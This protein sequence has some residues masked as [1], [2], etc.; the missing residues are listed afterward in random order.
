[1]R[2][3]I[4]ILIF[5]IAGAATL[6]GEETNS[7]ENKSANERTFFIF[8]EVT[9]SSDTGIGG[10]M[11]I[12]KAYHTEQPRISTL[13]GEVRYTE[14]KQF[15]SYFGLDHYFKKNR[16]RILFT[17]K[18]ARFP[19]LFYGIGNETS[20]TRPEDYSPEYV[21]ALMF[22]ERSIPS[23]IRIQC[24]FYLHNQ[25]LISA[26]PGG[27]LQSPGIAWSGGRFDAGP[28][29]A[30]LRDTRDNI[31]AARSGSLVK[32]EYRDMMFQNRGNS[33]SS[34]RGDIRAFFSPF[35]DVV[36]GSMG[37]FETIHG[38]A[39]FYLLSGLGGDELLRGYEFERFRDR[40]MLL[41]QQDLRFPVAGP[42]GG[43][44]FAAAGRVAPRF[45]DLFDGKY[46]A[47]YGGGLRYYFNKKDRLLVRFDCARGSD[48][49]GY[50]ISFGEAF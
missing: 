11:A 5:L 6:S 35:S 27:R 33:F 28:V 43:A 8:P 40:N 1:M 25:S 18:Y 26:E 50:Y 30:I 29:F 16:D 4:S 17:V 37:S 45:G 13:R 44:L 23:Q 22:Y 46:H 32:V 48:S 21:R 3:S 39:P 10:G 34:V 31:M 2:Y 15:V 41:L 9:Y 14:K 12:L 42:F 38:D 49:T 19:S 47:A 36:L 20:N 7:R 24:G